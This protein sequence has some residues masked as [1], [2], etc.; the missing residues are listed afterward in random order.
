MRITGFVE[1]FEPKESV[2]KIRQEC[3]LGAS[4]DST[5]YLSS[6]WG[7]EDVPGWLGV[8]TAT[9]DPPGLSPHHL[10]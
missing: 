8:T 10:L 1:V 2:R 4:A 5:V 3:H 9:G 7:R 6:R